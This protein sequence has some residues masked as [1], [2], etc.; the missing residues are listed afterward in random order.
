M[1]RSRHRP[2]AVVWIAVALGLA[3]L[4]ASPRSAM[5]AETSHPFPSHLSLQAHRG[6]AGLAPENTL[7]AFRRALELDA[8]GT[9]MDLQLTRDGV[10]VIL[11]DDTVD[12]TTDGR[13][14]IGDLT[15][16]EVKRLDAGAKFG[17]AFAGERIPTLRELI[18]LVKAS[19]NA[20][21]RLNLEIKFADGQEGR[22]EALEE[23]VLAVLSETGFLGRVI[24]QSFYH[25]SAAKMKR[26]APGIPAGLLVGQRRQ[27]TDPVA[28]VRQHG[29]DYYAPHHSLVTP[30]LLRTLHQAG[31]P[32]VTWTVNDPADMRRLIAMGLGA[33]PGDGM[34]SDYPDRL[35]ALRKAAG[36]R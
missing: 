31:I 36:P 18:D 35:V 21:F 33:L 23:R 8:D 19:G 15:L 14:R 10:V 32:V 26:L 12:R 4:G 9:E 6:A 25:P 20:R 13:G 30:D 27:P 1:G 34:I 29:V 3:G 22:P 17:P 2:T 24:T 5:T 28:A 11:H 7:A 16:A